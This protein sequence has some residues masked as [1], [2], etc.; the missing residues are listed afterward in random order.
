MACEHKDHS[1]NC[2]CNEGG[3]VEPLYV[4]DEMMTAYGPLIA[5][6]PETDEMREWLNKK[7]INAGG[8]EEACV[9]YPYVEM[10][11]DRDGIFRPVNGNIL[12][13]YT[14]LF[15]I[16]RAK[17]RFE[18]DEMKNIPGIFDTD[19]RLVARNF[20]DETPQ[21]QPPQPQ[22]Q[23]LPTAAKH[24]SMF[25]SLVEGDGDD[26]SYSFSPTI[27]DGG[28]D[29]KPGDFSD[30]IEA[31]RQGSKNMFSK[32]QPAVLPTMNIQ[33]PEGFDVNSMVDW[34]GSDGYRVTQ[35]NDEPDY[36]APES[37][38]Q[39]ENF[40]VTVT[41][42]DKPVHSVDAQ[43]FD[44]EPPKEEEYVSFK[45]G[46]V[47]E[48]EETYRF[49]QD[50]IENMPT[51]SESIKHAESVI[52]PNDPRCYRQPVDPMRG[53][54][55]GH[56]AFGTGMAMPTSPMFGGMGFNQSRPFVTG[57]S[58]DNRD[59][60]MQTPTGECFDLDK[61]KADKAR[62][63]LSPEMEELRRSSMAA[64]SP[65]EQARE[66][67][68][69][70]RL[71]NG[72]PLNQM[73]GS[74]IFTPAET[75]RAHAIV[76]QTPDTSGIFDPSDPQS[77]NNATHT[78]GRPITSLADLKRVAKRG[79]EAGGWKAGA[80][81]TMSRTINPFQPNPYQH[82]SSFA[83]AS[84]DVGYF[85]D[86][87][88]ELRIR[89]NNNDT[90][91]ML[92]TEE[93]F[94]HGEAFKVTVTE[95]I[96]Q[97]E[98]QDSYA[99]F[100]YKE[101]MN[102]EE[103]IVNVVQVYEDD[104]AEEK[105]TATFGMNYKE[106]SVF[107]EQRKAEDEIYILAR[108]LE[109]YN[110]TLADDL[111]WY[112]DNARDLQEFNQAKQEA[113]EQLMRYRNEDRLAGAKSNVMLIGDK[114]LV[115]EPRPVSMEQLEKMANEEVARSQTRIKSNEE[116]AKLYADKYRSPLNA[117]MK[118][119][120]EGG[121]TAY[122]RLLKLQ[123]LR[124]IR[125]IP[126]GADKALQSLHKRFEQLPPFVLNERDNYR[127]WKRMKRSVCLPEDRETFDRDFDIWW[128]KARGNDPSD[129]YRA[130]ELYLNKMY[131]ALNTHFTIVSAS[132]LTDEQKHAQFQQEII[133]RFREYDQGVFENP[134]MGI[135]D[136][137]EG[138][139]F[140]KTRELEIRRAHDMQ[141]MRRLYDPTAYLDEVRKHSALRNFQEGKGYVPTMDL[142]DRQEYYRKRQAF[143][144][145]IWKKPNRGT[146]T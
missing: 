26:D 6:V 33:M 112:K 14:N 30:R 94:K 44:V 129:Q 142:M 65:Q 97:E 10:D 96:E 132:Q 49:S 101:N 98:E 23:V 131:E 4:R 55:N 115:T 2:F 70:I 15:H 140:L 126:Y 57:P 117:Q 119:V 73:P 113:Q 69:L 143:L 19:Q 122:A 9:Q 84:D 100:P 60:F 38:S 130:R 50:K 91:W 107:N 71:N 54:F 87:E 93:N 32:P 75:Q 42:G 77:V 79:E 74:S 110:S 76:A 106:A 124:D 48:K 7:I 145:Q 125:V 52:H 86:A 62:R 66:R 37:S 56:G 22:P 13:R 53:A 27:S 25:S 82:Q 41:G 24:S 104:E 102:E 137:L 61:L 36:Y 95:E 81:G 58:M 127:L 64:P 31:Q 46:I 11:L 89:R 146:I 99:S 85:G 123:A 144:D 80:N 34:N 90:S 63:K 88:S 28:R 20:Q 116:L 135:N 118:A 47:D 5:G 128:N 134:H 78:A 16:M 72:L 92:P 141:E 18:F 59:G 45:C 109:R 133:K 136:I 17:R 121:G 29:Y 35:Y 8:L 12:C 138:F 1:C 111:L 108:E 68:E 21:Q 139:G 67:E 40:K 103:I 39:I 3:P 114:M 51:L 120:F 105:A 83:G 43:Q